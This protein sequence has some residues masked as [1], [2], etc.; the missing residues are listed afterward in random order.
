M[1]ESLASSKNDGGDTGS[2]LGTGS[3]V[4]VIVV[5]VVVVVFFLVRFRDVEVFLGVLDVDSAVMVDGE[6]LRLSY[7]S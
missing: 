6:S 1:L 5:A 7:S 3:S 4:D 2:I